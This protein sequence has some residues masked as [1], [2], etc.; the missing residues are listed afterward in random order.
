[1]QIKCLIVDLDNTLWNWFHSWHSGFRP[2]LTELEKATNL[3][4]EE[5]LPKIKIIHEKHKT[6]EYANRLDELDFVDK[7]ITDIELRKKYG[8]IFRE[9]SIGRDKGLSLYENVYETLIFLKS[10]GIKIVAYTDSMGL[11]TKERIYKLNL[12]GIIDNVY[13]P[14]IPIEKVRSV[15]E[16]AGMISVPDVQLKITSI[17]D[18]GTHDHKPNEK[19]LLHIISDQGFEVEECAYIGDSLDRDV[20]MAQRAGVIDIW[21]SYGKEIDKDEYELLKKVT[22][23]TPQNVE[24]EA[25]HDDNTRIIPTYTVSNFSQIRNILDIRH[26]RI[27]EFEIDIW[28]KAIDVQMHFNDMGM[29][30]RHIYFTIIAALVA[31]YGVIIRS[32]SVTIELGFF[33][34]SYSVVIMMT[35]IFITYL[36]YFVDRFWYHRLLMG[37]VYS[38]S[39]LEKRFEK[40]GYP[41]LGLHISKQSPVKYSFPLNILKG[42]V[43]R[44]TRSNDQIHSEGKIELLYKMILFV[45][46]TSAFFKIASGGVVL[47]YEGVSYSIYSYIFG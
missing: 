1:M 31:F 26:S 3:T 13:T 36:F 33:E 17:K 25:D 35:I 34:I 2:F 11:Y 8:D 45:T 7:N 30:V 32:Q 9:E 47:N 41:S 16:E 43:I 38:V 23:W 5:I 40:M 18:L 46:I 21:A 12:D 44:D 15:F 6:S 24:R 28:K 29:K 14:R 19:A 39:D 4:E 20:A 22:H 10:K 27:D 42:T 37:A